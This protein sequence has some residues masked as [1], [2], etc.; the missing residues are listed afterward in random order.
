MSLNK[1]KNRLGISFE[2]GKRIGDLLENIVY[3]ELKRKFEEIYYFKTV[4][5]YEIDFLVKEKEQIT[6]LI[7]VSMTLEDEKTKKRELRAL[8]KAATELKH[9]QDTKL[10]LLTMDESSSELFDGVEIEIINILEWLIL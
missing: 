3:L 5:N 7:Q 10:M 4:Q 1:I 8:V 9:T 6:H 2:V